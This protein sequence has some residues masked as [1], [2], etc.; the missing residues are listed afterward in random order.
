M[1]VK[2]I[3]S[4]GLS[5]EATSAY[6]ILEDL[7]SLDVEPDRD[8]VYGRWSGTAEALD[9][10]LIE[11]ELHGV[12]DLGDAPCIAVRSESSWRSSVST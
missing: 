4:L 7:V 12:V 9:A 5:V 10:A 1:I 6:L 11:L 2:K 3:F 8:T